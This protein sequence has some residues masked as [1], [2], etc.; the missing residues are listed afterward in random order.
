MAR[1][2]RDQYRYQYQP[3]PPP[4]INNHCNDKL[5]NLE[6]QC[7][8][9][10]SELKHVIHNETRNN[11]GL[12]SK[13]NDLTSK[14]DAAKNS[15]NIHIQQL[16]DLKVKQTQNETLI[17]SMNSEITNLKNETNQLVQSNK[18]LKLSNDT[19]SS[20]L[21]ATDAT[22]ATVEGF[23]TTDGGARIIDL[24]N[25]MKN[26]NLV[27]YDAVSSQNYTLDN[28]F[29]ET[30][31]TYTTD[32]QKVYYQLKVNNGLFTLN[33][34][35]LITFY[36]FFLLFAYLFHRKNPLMSIYLKLFIL[37]CIAIYPW[38]ISHI[39]YYVYYTW[40][41]VTAVFNGNPV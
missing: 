9:T 1:Y 41:F 6:K 23:G 7:D 34:Y 15:D 4:Q 26:N 27:L 19:S 24:I 30:K 37:F 11:S 14:L 31:N 8:A 21:N 36:A 29:Q 3:P 28:Y 5:A 39:E 25:S 38:I 35:L 13:I 32:D 16:N 33:F 17:A 2:Y 40:V 20:Y 10:I 18:S 12:N 22:K